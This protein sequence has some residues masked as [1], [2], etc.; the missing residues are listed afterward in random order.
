MHALQNSKI[1]NKNETHQFYSAEAF[2][3]S[4]NQLMKMAITVN[5]IDGRY[6]SKLDS[7]K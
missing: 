3:L 6:Q 2:N 1:N 7:H 4:D 5:T